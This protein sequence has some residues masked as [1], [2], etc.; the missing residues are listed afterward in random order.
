MLADLIIFV[1]KVPCIFLH[2]INIDEVSS[3]TLKNFLQSVIELL[4]V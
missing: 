3:I 4:Q 2:Y 1:Y